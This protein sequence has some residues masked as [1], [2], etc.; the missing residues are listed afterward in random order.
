MSLLLCIPNTRLKMC[1]IAFYFWLE[2]MKVKDVVLETE[3][4]LI[5]WL[6]LTNTKQLKI[7]DTFV[8]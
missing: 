7:G 5:K 3:I 6:S 1:K 8:I 2:A 4:F